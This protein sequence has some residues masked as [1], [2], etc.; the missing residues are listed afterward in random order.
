MIWAEDVVETYEVKILKDVNIQCDLFTEAR[1]FDMMVVNKRGRN[2]I[3]T[4]IVLPGDSRVNEKE[5]EEVEKY[6]K[7]EV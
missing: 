7:R 3:I 5:K 2:W 4:D 1:K 6:L